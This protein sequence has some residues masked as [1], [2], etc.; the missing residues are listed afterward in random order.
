MSK[1][2][3][4]PAP[5]RVIFFGPPR[6]GKTELYERVRRIIQNEPH[7]DIFALELAKDP[8][9]QLAQPFIRNQI[10][11]PLPG[12]AQSAYGLM[13]IDCDGTAAGQLIADPNTLNQRTGQDSLPA[14]L[15]QA[16]AIVLVID[17]DWNR[18]A[19][20]EV[21][22]DFRSFL[23]E[24]NKG[25]SYRREA[26]GMPVIISVTKCDT[27]YVE[28]VDNPTTWFQRIELRIKDIRKQFHTFFEEAVVEE[29]EPPEI[30]DFGSINLKILPTSKKLPNDPMFQE[31]QD[32]TGGFGADAITEEIIRTAA[33]YRERTVLSSYRLKWT[34]AGAM[35]LLG[36]MFLGLILINT[37]GEPGPVEQLTRRLKGY[38]NQEGPPEVRFSEKLMPWHQEELATIRE[39]VWFANLPDEMQQFVRK[40]QKEFAAY[41]VYLSKFKPPQFSPAEARTKKEVSQL[42]KEL[43]TE[44]QPPPEYMQA[45]SE[46]EASQMRAKWKRDLQLLD[47]AEEQLHDWYRN[48][49]RR[50]TTDLLVETPSTSW[51]DDVNALLADSEI[52]PFRPSEAIPGSPTVPIRR[53]RPLTYATAYQYE[54][55]DNARRDWLFA[56]QKLA[57][58]RDL[59]IA[60]GMVP[61]PLGTNAILDLPEPTS[62]LSLSATLPAERMDALKE[63]FPRA[64]NR[65][66]NWSAANFPDPIR[67][68]LAKRLKLTADTGTR[69]VRQLILSELNLGNNRADTPADWVSLPDGF[70]KRPAMQEWGRFMRLL[71]GWA[72]PERSDTDPITDL[73]G[74]L[75]RPRFALE[76][77]AVEIFIPNALRVDRLSPDSAFS[78][79]FFTR[80]GIPN[81][82]ELKQ[83]GVGTGVDGG[84]KY[85]F[86]PGRAP[87]KLTLVPGDSISAG[88]ALRSDAGRYKLVWPTAR[89]AT[90][91]VERLTREPWI[92]RQQAPA[93]PQRATGVSVKWIPE[94][95]MVRVPELLPEIP[96]VK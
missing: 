16:D 79:T 40:R 1:P 74:F 57:D 67:Q 49:I 55:T 88:L 25:R 17:A 76:I 86:V 10:T 27:L 52:P 47:A 7:E 9:K 60:L 61:D 68:E 5:L 34:I 94:S 30:A 46:T 14:I 22:K 58:L 44:L 24:F 75:K 41:Q 91:L 90:F 45:W 31:Y 71:L 84:V 32:P 2:S 95:G 72:E 85:R 11:I 51:R 56:A 70:L 92:E 28:G 33:E 59:C 77:E 65:N 82:I 96:G 93:I 3:Y 13:L 29:N 83:Q 18:I 48:L 37:I 54:R 21:F 19:V 53:G 12:R 35:A 23:Q 81:S 8:N 43:E 80:E 66:A 39:S 50:A 38:Q 64:A 26:G 78:A 87:A 4:S 20:K 69:H 73:I 89:T 6:S 15:R 36:L 63:R 42:E 62:D